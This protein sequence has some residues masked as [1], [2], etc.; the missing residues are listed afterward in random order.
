MDG[1]EAVSHLSQ[2][3]QPAVGGTRGH[4]QRAGSAWGGRHRGV[5]SP[6]DQRGLLTDQELLTGTE[7]AHV[8]K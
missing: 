5:S 6:K 4:V 2:D 8:G 3:V 1:R 7:G